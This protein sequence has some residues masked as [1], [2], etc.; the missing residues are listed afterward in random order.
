MATFHDDKELRKEVPLN[1]VTV[2]VAFRHHDRE[3]KDFEKWAQDTGGLP[4]EHGA[5]IKFVFPETDKSEDLAPLFAQA[6]AHF[7]QLKVALE[8]KGYRVV[9]VQ[10]F[11]KK[12]G[13]LTVSNAIVTQSRLE[14]TKGK[15]LVFNA[16][17]KA[18]AV[19]PPTY[20]IGGEDSKEAAMALTKEVYGLVKALASGKQIAPVSEKPPAT[21][22]QVTNG[23]GGGADA[24]LPLAT[25]PVAA[26]LPHDRP[27]KAL[28]VVAR[29]VK[30]ILESQISVEKQSDA[31]AHLIIAMA[32]DNVKV[33][34]PAKVASKV[35]DMLGE[36]KRDDRK[37]AFPEE[38]IRYVRSL[39]KE[40]G[41]AQER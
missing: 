23:W 31:L 18:L 19:L 38:I 1:G 25:A 14:G 40:P 35:S 7:G 24:F 32:R 41:A 21:V 17:G 28:P 27:S 30:T 2:K 12:L 15:E 16:G 4:N 26:A 13:D 33:I 6:R 20:W 22:D 5:E 8:A 36:T 3:S 29:K 37:K 34:D 9:K 10:G 39:P 11:G